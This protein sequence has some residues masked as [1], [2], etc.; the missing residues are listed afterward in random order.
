MPN[1]DE[2]VGFGTVGFGAVAFG[3]AGPFGPGRT[4]RPVLG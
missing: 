1:T 3:A 4:M 2:T